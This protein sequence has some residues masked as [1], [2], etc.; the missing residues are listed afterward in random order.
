MAKKDLIDKKTP[1]N[2]WPLPALICEHLYHLGHI[3]RDNGILDDQAAG[4]D[5]TQEAKTFFSPFSSNGTFTLIDRICDVS[6]Q[7]IG[8][9]LPIRPDIVFGN[10]LPILQS[11]TRL[12]TVLASSMWWERY[13]QVADHMGTDCVISIR[14]AVAV[15]ESDRQAV[16]IKD[17]LLELCR[18]VGE[19]NVEINE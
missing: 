15:F 16:H 9:S 19:T 18:A 10:Q 13:E 2:E 3:I 6:K 8:V 7:Y 17:A 5:V 11:L 12:G 14:T 4:K 1:R